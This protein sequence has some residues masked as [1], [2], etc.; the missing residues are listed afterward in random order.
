M[1]KVEKT[2]AIQAIQPNISGY[3]RFQMTR[4][5][6]SH[7]QIYDRVQQLDYKAK[8]NNGKR[9]SA[10]PKSFLSFSCNQMMDI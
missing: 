2:Q 8:C 9:M 1:L 10:N 4:H 6:Y 7:L 5:E 3:I